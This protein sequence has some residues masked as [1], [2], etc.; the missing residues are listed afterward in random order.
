MRGKKIALSIPRRIV[1]DVLH[2]ASG[3]PTVPVER[4]FNL[5]NLAQLR[6]QTPTR[7]GW[8]TLF[9]KAYALVCHEF[10]VL[11]QAYV[12]LPWPHLR[13]YPSSTATIAF[14]R[15]IN[16]E[17]GVLFARIGDPA[18][19][20]LADLQQR[21]T[22]YSDAPLESVRAFRKQL[23]FARYPRMVRR[24]LMWLGLNLP[25]SR[26]QHF[27]T[28]GVSVYS[29]LGA[30]S[31]HPLS[32]LTTNLTYGVIRSGVVPVR[33]IYD[34]RVTDGAIIARV[35]ERLETTLNST[36]ANEL[37]EMLSSPQKINLAA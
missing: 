16:G 9:I 23:R 12:K 15:D 8:P 33:L 4:T 25:G 3:I 28:F 34:H 2:F 27:G 13:E 10:P 20:S 37:R 36:I 14:E 22:R 7:I 30:E 18:T 1:C 32:P 6:A 26:S 35:L 19:R 31:L 21:I 17:P 5:A 24:G 11:R 29:S